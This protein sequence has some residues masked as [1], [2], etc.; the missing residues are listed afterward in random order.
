MARSLTSRRCVRQ[1]KFKE[2]LRRLPKW[3]LLKDVPGLLWAGGGARQSGLAGKNAFVSG[4]DKA[5]IA[6][7]YDVS[8]EFYQI[9]LD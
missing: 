5:A 9:F 8:N 7:H 1:G 6:H 2:K 3:Q 4:S